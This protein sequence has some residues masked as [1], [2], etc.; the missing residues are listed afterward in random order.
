MIKDG[1]HLHFLVEGLYE[2]FVRLGVEVGQGEVFQL[3][4]DV[5]HSDT[6]CEGCV[7]FHC[8]ACDPLPPGLIEG[9]ESPHVVEAIGPVSPG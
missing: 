6:V 9:T 4:L 7:Y 2:D 3:C 5:A 8:L 1:T